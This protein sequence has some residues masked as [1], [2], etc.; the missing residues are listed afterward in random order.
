[1]SQVGFSSR[2]RGLWHSAGLSLLVV[3]VASLVAVGSPP[4]GED[5]GKPAPLAVSPEAAPPFPH[6]NPGLSDQLPSLVDKAARPSPVGDFVDSLSQNDAGFEVLVGQS[7]ILTVKT[8]LAVRG[9][10]AALVAVGDPTVVDFQVLSARQIRVGGQRIGVTDLSVVTPDG[11]TYS[12]EIRVVTDLNVLRGQLRAMFPDASIRLAN[13]RDHV[14]VEGQVRD[15]AQAAR[16][17][18][19]IELYLESV[20]A[21]EQKKVTAQRDNRPPPPPGNAQPG[22]DGAPPAAL[23]ESSPVRQSQAAIAQPR[24]I[25][26]LTVPGSKQVLLKVRVAEL[27]RTA[28]RQIGSDLL[29]GKAGGPQI[30]TRIGGAGVNAL[31]TA[32]P[33]TGL[34]ELLSG[35]A[36][37]AFGIFEQADFAVLFSALRRN[38]LLRVL[39]EPNLVAMNGHQASFLAGGEFPVPVPQ[40]GNTGGAGAVTVQFREFGVRLS[41]LPTITDGDVIKL[42][43]NPEVSTID[44]ALGT[45]LVAGGAPVPG[46]STR[47]AQT[48]VELKQGQTLAVAGLLQLTMDGSTQRIPLMGDLPVI[49]SFFSNTTNSR[50]EKELIVLVTPYLVEGVDAC[51]VPPTPGDEVTT[52]SDLEFFLHNRIEGKGPD[53]RATTKYDRQLQLVKCQMRLDASHVRGPHGFCD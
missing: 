27:N 42:S 47:R 12:F 41:F 3:C 39:A 49:G 43:V 33:L 16:V 37:T 36:T 24:V 52:P 14:V 5:G 4:G 6:A 53:W 29:V 10:P 17:I 21:G 1:M 46:L 26:L 48:T 25:N 31:A 44:P 40:G 22:A 18:E 8:D 23:P 28:F 11:A 45:T 19:A 32:A 35:S 38:T 13:I 34:T 7:R 20:V 51:K 9:K 50:V 15:T 2:R 30:G